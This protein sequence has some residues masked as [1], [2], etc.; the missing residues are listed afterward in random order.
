MK[1]V[2]AAMSGGVDSAVTAL[3]LKQAGYECGG[4]TMLLSG[5]EGAC[6]Q[7]QDALDA[8]AV[9]EKLHIPFAV[10]DESA[11]FYEKVVLP[12]VASYEQGKTPNPC[13]RCNCFLKF[14]SLLEYAEKEGYDGIATGHYARIEYKNGRCQLKKAADESKDQSYVLYQLTQEQLSKTLFPL[15]EMTK[16]EVRAVAEQHGFANAHKKESQDICF[17]PDGDYAGF[18]CRET[19]KTYPAGEFVT[20]DGRVLGTHKGLIRYTVGQRKG[21]GLALPE[22][23]FVKQKDVANN[24]VM[25]CPAAELKVDRLV[26]ENFNWVSVAPQEVGVQ[27]PVT[28]RARYRQKEVPAVLRVLGGGKVELRFETPC[29]VAAPG[30]AAVCYDGETVVGGGEIE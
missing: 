19:G 25:L 5:A 28:V 3:L 2:L 16:A 4:V 24:R 7:K 22:P 29:V 1:R 21:L 27:L 15:G 20:A 9:A 26:A 8:A 18:I 23:Y 13:I 11:R 14:G 30:Q 10:C 6:V 12:F 17:V